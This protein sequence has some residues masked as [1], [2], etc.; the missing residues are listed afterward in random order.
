LVLLQA[1]HMLLFTAAVCSRVYALCSEYLV[2]KEERERSL[3]FST[4]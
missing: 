1:L 3:N 2:C 4:P